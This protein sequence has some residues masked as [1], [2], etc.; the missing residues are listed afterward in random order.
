MNGVL[1]SGGPKNPGE[2]FIPIYY[3]AKETGIFKPQVNS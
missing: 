2:D 3:G 1:L